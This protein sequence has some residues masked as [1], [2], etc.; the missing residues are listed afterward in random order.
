VPE[1]NADFVQATLA[2][3]RAFDALAAGG[4]FTVSAYSEQ[5][6]VKNATVTPTVVV[7][8]TAIN[9]LLP[10]RR[11]NVPGYFVSTN[12]APIQVPTGR[13]TPPNIIGKRREIL[14]PLGPTAR[15]VNN[16]GPGSFDKSLWL[17]RANDQ[18]TIASRTGQYLGDASAFINPVGQRLI[19]ASA[20]VFPPLPP[21]NGSAA[22]LAV[23]PFSVPSGSAYTYDP[24]LSD[25]I[26]LGPGLSG[27]AVV[28]ATDSSVFTSD[29]VD[30]FGNDGAPLDQT[31]WFLALGTE[32][33]TN[34]T[35]NLGIDFELNPLAL[36]EINLPSSFL[37]G[38][39]SYSDPTSEAALIDQ[40]I[41]GAVAKALTQNGSEVDLNGFD[42]FP[43]GTTFTAANGGV[44]YAD[45]VDAGVV[46]TPEPSTW[47]LLATG[48]LGFLGFRLRRR[49]LSLA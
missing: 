30:N 10:P 22:G 48:S 46:G 11:F 2:N 1:A 39:G 20:T 16:I 41:D 25:N 33:S 8:G 44:V 40:A 24:S 13:F 21:P 17:K 49:K 4:D 7:N 14:E 42:P 35:S 28:W 31:L 29:T 6:G 34:S 36:K 9:P 43:A 37:A 27:G 38:L 18:V 19:Y 47:I 45:G 15:L 12:G 32:S 3:G 26:Q 5:N 23:D